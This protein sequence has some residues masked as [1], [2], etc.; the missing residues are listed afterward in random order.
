MAKVTAPICMAF[1]NGVSSDQ[2]AYPLNA[3]DVASNIATIF[4]NG[5]GLVGSMANGSFTAEDIKTMTTA[6][7]GAIAA[8]VT[9]TM[10]A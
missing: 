4:G 1:T 7:S 2:A 10:P 9:T 5:N 3:T 6:L 8:A